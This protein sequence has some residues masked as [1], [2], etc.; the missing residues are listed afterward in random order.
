LQRELGTLA[1]EMMVDIAL[2]SGSLLGTGATGCLTIVLRVRFDAIA[3]CL[4]HR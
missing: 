1:S 3:S 2:G 4:I